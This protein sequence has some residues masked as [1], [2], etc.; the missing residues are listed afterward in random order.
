MSRYM[1]KKQESQMGLKHGEMLPQKDIPDCTVDF[2]L[3]IQSLLTYINPDISANLHK[4]WYF[5]NSC[6]VMF[7]SA[8]NKDTIFFTLD[9]QFFSGYGLQDFPSA[10][11][12]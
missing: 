6:L 1:E 3:H 2:G 9:P 10:F 12:S 7:K 11:H 8:N 4:S 5:C